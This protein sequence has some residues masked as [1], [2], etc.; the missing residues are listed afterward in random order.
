[1]TTIYRYIR[2]ADIGTVWFSGWDIT[3]MLAPHGEYSALG[4]FICCK[5]AHP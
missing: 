4:E 5:E 2:F 3:P 1:M